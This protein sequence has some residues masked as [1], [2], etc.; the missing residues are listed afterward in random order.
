VAIS[1][2]FT[3]SPI[4][5]PPL[6]ALSRLGASEQRPRPRARAHAWAVARP[7]RRSYGARAGPCVRERGKGME[8]GAAAGPW[9]AEF[10][11]SVRVSSVF[12]FLFS[13]EI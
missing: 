4:H 10:G 11:R 9:W 2:S 5:P 1:L 12:L 6:G 3:G 8:G 7:G 13:L